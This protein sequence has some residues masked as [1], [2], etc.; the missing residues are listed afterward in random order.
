MGGGKQLG[1][2]REEEDI[3]EGKIS[4]AATLKILSRHKLLPAHSSSFN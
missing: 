3:K 4:K 1:S 2:M